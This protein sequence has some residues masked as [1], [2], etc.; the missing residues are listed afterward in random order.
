MKIT[1][2]LILL[3]VSLPVF[4]SSIDMSSM[5]L[6]YYEPGHGELNS[7]MDNPSELGELSA[8]R[9]HVLA[10]LGQGD[11]SDVFSVTIADGYQLSGLSLRR[12][13]GD[14]DHNNLPSL[15]MSSDPFGGNCALQ[16]TLSRDILGVDLLSEGSF[17]ELLSENEFVFGISLNQDGDFEVPN[18]GGLLAYKFE[19]EVTPVPL[20]APVLLLL[21]GLVSLFGWKRFQRR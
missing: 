5:P 9:H 19:L 7:E 17:D 4:S 12:F 2:A 18:E 15:C 13:Y 20:P 3:M 11:V 21:S 10:Y 6:K 8:G 1:L 14:I 16:T